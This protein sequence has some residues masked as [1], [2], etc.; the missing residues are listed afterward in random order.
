MSFRGP[1]CWD[2]KLWELFIKRDP[3]SSRTG[4]GIV[5]VGFGVFR[6]KISEQVTDAWLDSPST[7]GV[8]PVLIVLFSAIRPAVIMNGF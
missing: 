8:I 2:G 7:I 6:Q 3:L 1:L 4:D 5:L